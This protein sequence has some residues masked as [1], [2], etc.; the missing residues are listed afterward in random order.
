MPKSI[1]EMI[2]ADAIASYYETVRSNAIPYLGE[3][4][5]PAKKQIGLKLEWI[6]G[7]DNLPVQLTPSA[8]DTK[9]TLRDR[10][11]VS[12]EQVK[13]PF[14]R[15]SMRLGEEDR[16]LLLMFQNERSNP[17]ATQIM[18]R[19]F[20]DVV[21]LVD[22]ALINPEVMRMGIIVDGKF[23]I[24]TKA[25]S[26][27][28][29][30]YDYNYDTDDTWKEKNVETLTGTAKWSD[31]ENSNPVKDIIDMKRDAE[32]RGITLT[33]AIIGYNTWLDI[34]A[35][36]KIRLDMNPVAGNNII[37]TDELVSR[38]LEGKTGVR[39]QIYTKMY[40]D[41]D[42]K[43]QYFFPQTGCCTLL[44]G[45]ALGSTWFGTTPEEADLMSGNTDAN[46]SIV[47]TGVA[48]GTKKESLPVNVVN[49]VAEIVLPSFENMNRVFNIKY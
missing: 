11:G 8:F 35:N 3:T 21:T 39:F 6:K 40:K 17:Y 15:E 26:G 49:W 27:T 46:V 16:Q 29:V 28:Y 25:D 23:S 43:E 22:G 2:T 13:M 47:N 20:D 18:G 37:V 42:G 4:L 1:F 19:L 31:H 44:P 36:K 41:T 34:M 45:T 24:A 48:I 30:S 14:F 10:G 7:Y 32:L 12:M 9:P 38:Y 33:R 5:F